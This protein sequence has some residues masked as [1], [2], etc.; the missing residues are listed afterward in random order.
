MW[1]NAKIWL[2][3]K[4]KHKKKHNPNWPRIHDHPYR[5]LINGGSGSRK[6]NTLFNLISFYLDTCE[7]YL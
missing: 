7:I 3:Y 5:M 4:S 1:L 2:Y 6:T